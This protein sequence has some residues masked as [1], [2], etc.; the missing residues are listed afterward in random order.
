MSYGRCHEPEPPTAVTREEWRVTGDPGDRY[1][2]YSFVWT[3]LRGDTD[4]EASARGFIALIAEHGG[5]WRDGPH[6]HRRTV[7]ETPWEPA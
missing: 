1:P 4:P 7:T 5:T 3:P 6:L 2:P